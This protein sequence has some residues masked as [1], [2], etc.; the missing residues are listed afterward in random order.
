MDILEELITGPEYAEKRRCSVRT[1]ERERVT[2]TG[3]KFIKIGRKVLYRPRDVLEF[4]ERHSCRST[5]EVAR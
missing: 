5:S 1:I 3:C 2:G 4:I